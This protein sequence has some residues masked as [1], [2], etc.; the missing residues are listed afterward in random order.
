MASFDIDGSDKSHSTSSIS[1]IP[2]LQATSS[3]YDIVIVG[4]GVLGTVLAI[5]LANSG[6]SVLVVER[7]LCPPNSRIV[8]ELLQPGGCISL[9]KLGLLEAL[10][11]IDAVPCNGYTV[12]H[13]ILGNALI[14]YPKNTGDKIVNAP[15]HLKDHWNSTALQQGRSFHH[16]AFIGSLRKKMMGVHGLDILEATVNDLIECGTTG[17]KIIGVQC[18]TKSEKEKI[19]V[20]APLTIIA[21]GYASKCE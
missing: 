3:S 20:L 1:S 16:G 10:E 17:G 6:R 9:D 13:P 12:I 5:S 18:T 15:Q 8:G 14:P 19:Q 21:D 7:D 11:E 2:A 4:S